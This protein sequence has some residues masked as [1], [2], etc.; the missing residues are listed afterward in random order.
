MWKCMG[1]DVPIG[2]L[3]LSMDLCVFDYVLSRIL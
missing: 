2:W 1:K 3:Q